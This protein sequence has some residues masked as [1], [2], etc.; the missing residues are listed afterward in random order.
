MTLL[1]PTGITALTDLPYSV[2]EALRLALVFNSWVEL[3][4]DEQPPKSI[5]F[6]GKELKAWWKAVERRREA[7][8]SGKGDSGDIRDVPIDGPTERNAALDDLIR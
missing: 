4:K 1:M 5:W 8:F 6:D 2:W 3:P 7:K